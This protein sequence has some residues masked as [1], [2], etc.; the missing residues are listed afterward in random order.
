MLKCKIDKKKDLISVKAKGTA[1]ELM[2][3]TCCIIADLYRNINNKAPAVA[4]V[5]KN[6]LIGMLLDPQSPVWKEEWQ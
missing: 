4:P 1:K 2:I 5:F 3:D 6:E